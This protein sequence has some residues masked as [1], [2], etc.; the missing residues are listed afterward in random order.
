MQNKN[1]EFD[2][3]KILNKHEYWQKLIGISNVYF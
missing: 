2:Y 1:D 3:W